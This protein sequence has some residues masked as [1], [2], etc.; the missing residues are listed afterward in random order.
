MQG[1]SF[2]HWSKTG[3]ACPT[4]PSVDR[5]VGCRGFGPLTTRG[6]SGAARGQTGFLGSFRPL[7][8]PTFGLSLWS[9][10]RRPFRTGFSRLPRRFILAGGRGSTDGDF[11]STKRGLIPP[12]AFCDGSARGSTIDLF[13]GFST[14]A[15]PFGPI[16]CR[17]QIIAG[18]V[19]GGSKGASTTFRAD[20]GCG[21]DDPSSPFSCGR[22]PISVYGVETNRLGVYGA[23]S[24]A[25]ATPFSGRRFAYCPFGGGNSVCGGPYCKPIRTADALA[26]VNRRICRHGISTTAFAACPSVHDGSFSDWGGSSGGVFDTGSPTLAPTEGLISYVCSSTRPKD[27]GACPICTEA[28]P[29]AISEDVYRDSSTPPFSLNL[30]EG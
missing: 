3:G 29:C 1:R 30:I 4:R 13:K 16:F 17:W 9:D 21:V 28:T 25:L 10:D 26:K 12:V 6:G 11:C 24:P 14:L 15:I 27:G 20:D 23:I 18:P 7:G 19:D 5:G 2:K 22:R 8:G